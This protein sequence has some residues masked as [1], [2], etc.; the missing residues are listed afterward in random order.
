M[1]VKGSDRAPGVALAEHEEASIESA[2][3]PRN[4]AKRAP[5]LSAPCAKTEPRKVTSQRSLNGA[6]SR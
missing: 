5:P 3:S 6:R 4:I 1:R 2:T